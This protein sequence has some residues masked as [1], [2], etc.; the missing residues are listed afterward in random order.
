VQNRTIDIN[1]RYL[2][3]E[4]DHFSLRDDQF[5]EFCESALEIFK[6]KNRLYNDAISRTGVL[7]ACVEI[8]GV[9]ARLEPLV[10]QDKDFPNSIGSGGKNSEAILNAL[11][12]LHNYSVIAL[13]M[14]ED[15]N[16]RGESR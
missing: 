16:W 15:R 7:G 12:D 8:I 4:K 14:L 9:A 5:K 10:L 1:G 3:D 2:D 11:H 13:M 6:E